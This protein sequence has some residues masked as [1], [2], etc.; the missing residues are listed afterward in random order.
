[1][2]RTRHYRQQAPR[3]ADWSELWSRLRTLP[4]AVR[5]SALADSAARIALGGTP[6]NARRYS[7]AEAVRA[8]MV[9]R[10][11]RAVAPNVDTVQTTPVFT[12]AGPRGPR[13]AV[14]VHLA[15]VLH[16]PLAA[17]ADQHRAAYDVLR[18]AYPRAQWQSDEYR[19]DV[20]AGRLHRVTPD[21]PADAR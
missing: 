5:L 16:L 2:N 12:E 18:R 13:I 19:Y 14:R 10:S 4:A 11:L 3:A 9:A 17:D 20:R 7:A 15:D 21:M 6:M 8:V 1:M